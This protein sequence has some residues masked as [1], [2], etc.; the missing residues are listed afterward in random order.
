MDALKQQL[1]KIQEQLGALSGTQRMLVFSLVTVMVL[2]VLL[3]SRYA[4]TPDVI[5]LLNQAVRDQDLVQ[6]QNALQGRGISVRS[7]NGNLMVS[8]DDRLR[9]L[10]VIAPMNLLPSNST[11]LMDEYLNGGNPFESQNKNDK[12]FQLFL[13]QQLRNTILMMDGVR[14]ASVTIDPS[15]QFRF[16]ATISPTA[17][18]FVKTTSPEI[19][20][21]AFVDGV[22]ALVTGSVAGL[23]KTDV[24]MV[25]N[26]RS[27]NTD[28][29]L[30]SGSFG[31][32]LLERQA[33]WE[34]FNVKKVRG[35]L[36]HIDGLQVALSVKINLESRQR[37]THSIDD[38]KSKEAEINAK[39]SESGN[40]TP[41]PADPGVAANTGT[42]LAIPPAGGN[43]STT[44]DTVT[45]MENFASTTD[46]ST[47]IP[48]GE[49]TVVAAT[50]A[51]PRSFFVN[52]IRG[53]DP[54]AKEPDQNAVD[55]QIAAERP[56]LQESVKNALGMSDAQNVLITSYVDTASAILPPD[57]AGG[58]GAG[59]IFTVA[60][61]GNM[62][63][64]L[65]GGL[66][67]VSL[68]M[69]M[70]IVRKAT[71]APLRV[72]EPAKKSRPDIGEVDGNEP[73]IGIAASG[74]PTLEAMELGPDDMESQQVVDQVN[75][76]VKEDPEAASQLIKRWLNRS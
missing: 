43:N 75:S 58:G 27:R 46:E 4:A 16:G 76:M 44:E 40:S 15:N 45:K 33:Q 68:F 74:N 57:S 1:Q 59:G 25:I 41:P 39:T 51:I 70:M 47:T 73:L 72:P 23:K 53:R 60:L 22:A 66:A 65:I 3:W 67:L 7:S 13:S 48:A 20:N 28:S 14:E 19:A 9:A 17:A 18:V 32:D 54:S 42:L 21:S 5:P 64:V 11:N 37:R 30:G 26:N 2:T 12:R 24:K 50:V 6:I 55:A 63:E 29:G 56:T 52:S 38:V 69:L 8:P 61:G 31:T 35:Y 62:K 36:S 34:D 71:P 10:A 49:A